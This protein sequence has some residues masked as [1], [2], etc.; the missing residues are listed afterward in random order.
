MDKAVE[1]I[2]IWMQKNF[3]NPKL[4]AVLVVLIIV[5]AYI[6]PYIDANFLFYNRIE[7]RVDILRELSEIDLET[8][9]KS[10]AL[11]EEY[12]AVLSEIA[13]QRKWS[14]F[15]ANTSGQDENLRNISFYKFVSGGILMWIIT[16][17]VPF[18]DTFESRGSKV[19]AFL[20]CT[21]VGVILGWIGYM[22]P[23]FFNPLINYI[24][25]PSLQLVLLIS[26]V[27]K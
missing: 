2:V 5:G 9:S 21:L 22:I 12:N 18:M 15:G 8:I 26:L 16:I 4:Y 1:L 7:K 3:R 17:L 11:Q 19:I 27:S 25:F 20:I 13:N 23:T 6:F 10:P 14:I 24:G